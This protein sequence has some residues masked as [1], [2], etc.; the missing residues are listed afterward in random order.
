[1]LCSRWLTAVAVFVFAL[2]A[3]SCTSN[4]PV[5]LPP[6]PLSPTATPV[7]VSPTPV[8]ATVTPVPPTPEPTVEPTATPLPPA[9]TA[10][11]NNV[12]FTPILAGVFRYPATGLDQI[13][14]NGEAEALWTVIELNNAMAQMLATESFDDLVVY[15]RIKERG[16]IASGYSADIEN[17]MR[18]TDGVVIVSE[19]SVFTEVKRSVE[20]D[21]LVLTLCLHMDVEVLDP[22]VTGV[23]SFKAT[24]TRAYTFATQGVGFKLVGL[25]QNPVLDG[26]FVPCEL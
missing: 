14:S 12:S 26:D 24:M 20:N 1:M 23:E 7:P 8:P 16:L 21:Q 5:A 13:R 22:L 18:N 15:D 6:T 2:T 17:A 9:P 19:D 3:S 25:E 10:T 4:E 11:A